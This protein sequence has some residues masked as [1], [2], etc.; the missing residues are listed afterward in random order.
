MSDPRLPELSRLDPWA[1]WSAPGEAFGVDL[2]VMGTTGAFAVVISDAEGYV[3]IKLGRVTVGGKTAASIRS[4]AGKARKLRGTLSGMQVDAP[5]TA[6]LVL[7]RAMIGSPRE[8]RGIWV[9]RP[10]DLPRL[11]AQRPNK[12]ARQPAKRA[13]QALGAKVSATRRDQNRGGLL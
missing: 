12:V 6:V 2:V 9:A 10:Q 7:T 1:F 8:I 3:D 11:I 4:L 5:A 13:A